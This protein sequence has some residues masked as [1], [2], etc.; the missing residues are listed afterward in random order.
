MVLFPAVILL[1][2]V[3][4]HRNE[5]GVVQQIGSVILKS[6][7]ILSKMDLLQTKLYLKTKFTV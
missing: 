6:R 5:D 2:G 4:Y 7:N 1:G 3:W